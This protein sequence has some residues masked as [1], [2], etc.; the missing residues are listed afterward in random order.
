MC[1]VRAMQSDRRTRTRTLPATTPVEQPF[2]LF[3]SAIS[4]CSPGERANRG[5]LDRDVLAGC[6][7]LLNS[8][9]RCGA[10]R[11]NC[12]PQRTSRRPG[13]GNAPS[14]RIWSGPRCILFAPLR[15]EQPAHAA[16]RPPRR[17]VEGASNG[18]EGT[19]GGDRLFCRHIR[20]PQPKVRHGIA[21]SFG[22]RVQPPAWLAGPRRERPPVRRSSRILVRGIAGH[23][24]PC[25]VSFRTRSELLSPGSVFYPGLSKIAAHSADYLPPRA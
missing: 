11:S 5:F 13:A 21:G 18:N 19:I 22:L 8:R 25:S 4:C 20:A 2:D 15:G 24:R 23:R 17:G 14:S 12:V 10:C 3:D 7:D 9:V 6:C 1:L 16:Y